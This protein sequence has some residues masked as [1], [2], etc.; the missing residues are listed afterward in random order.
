MKRGPLSQEEKDYILKNSTKDLAALSK[1]LKRNETSI[2]NFLDEVSPEQKQSEKE[3][4]SQAA[5]P[6]ETLI[7]SNFTRNK[8]YGA[9]I[10]TE[11]VSMLS[12]EVRKVK[13]SKGRSPVSSRY[14]NAIH[15]IKPNKK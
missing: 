10:M 5:E 15:I 9:V 11:N 3:E 14:K 8:K 2:K 7:S 12:D 13:A 4:T 1:K 6:E